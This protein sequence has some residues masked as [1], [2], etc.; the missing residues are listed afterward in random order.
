M[1]TTAVAK[2]TDAIGTVATG[3]IRARHSWCWRD[4]L[5][6]AT[7]TARVVAGIAGAKVIAV[8]EGAGAAH[9]SVPSWKTLA[10]VVTRGFRAAS[11]LPY[12]F[13]VGSNTFT[14]G[15]GDDVR[16]VTAGPRATC[17]HAH[18]KSPRCPRPGVLVHGRQMARRTRQC[19]Q[20]MAPR[21]R[22]CVTPHA[23]SRLCLLTRRHM[24][25]QG[26]ESNNT[27]PTRVVRCGKKLPLYVAP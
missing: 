23:T 19:H 22:N 1:G 4:V 16:V 3:T 18:R 17:T 25:C 6:D 7:F 13:V 26:C 11:I 9:V 2:E 8:V 15:E 27:V 5:H 10:A 21:S 20:V 12:G 24:T 14:A